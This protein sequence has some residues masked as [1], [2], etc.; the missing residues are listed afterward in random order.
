MHPIRSWSARRRARSTSQPGVAAPRTTP[1]PV[2]WR[3]RPTTERSDPTAGGCRVAGDEAEEEEA[4]I[5]H[6]LTREGLGKL[7]ALLEKPGFG[8]VVDVVSAGIKHHVDEEENEIFPKLRR[9]A[10]ERLDR[11]DPEELEADVTRGGGDAKRSH[12]SN[13]DATRSEL[14]EQAK[15]AD[16]KG[17]S[18]MTKDELRDAL[19]EQR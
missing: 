6:D 8:A 19:A 12:G 4:E 13:G 14:Y 9:Q 1:L 2:A 17:R 7:R 18:S 15:D 3:S 11:L 5:E 16:I 10:A